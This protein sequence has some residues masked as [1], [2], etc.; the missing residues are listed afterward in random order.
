M[1][2]LKPSPTAPIRASSA[3]RA[4]VKK[5]SLNSA[6][7]FIW[8]IGR[9]SMPGW[10]TS[11]MKYDMPSMLGNVDV[12][13]GHE[14]APVGIGGPGVPH[15]L[16]VDH[17]LVAIANGTGLDTGQIRSCSWLA[18]E[19]APVLLATGQ[20]RAGSGA[21]AR[22]C[23]GPGSPWLPWPGPTPTGGPSTP[24]PAIS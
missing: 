5:V 10:S 13:P 6:R 20:R 23:R 8:R 17:P 9:I 19:L 14:Q 3:T 11:M 24:R 21:S 18:E 7:P 2:T 4:S 12:G 16:P 1:A 22:R 15:L